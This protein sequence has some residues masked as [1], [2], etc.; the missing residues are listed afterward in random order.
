MAKG[1]LERCCVVSSSPDPPRIIFPAMGAPATSSEF[2]RKTV[3]EGEG[4][5]P[6]IFSFLVPNLKFV[7]AICKK[8]CEETV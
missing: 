2:A 7:I 5:G 1:I 4:S 6:A 8:E 3:G